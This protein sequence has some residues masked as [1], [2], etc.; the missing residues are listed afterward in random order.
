MRYAALDFEILDTWRTS[1][2][3]VGCVIFEDGRMVDSFYSLVRPPSKIENWHCVQAH[4]LTYADVKNAPSFPDVWEK[5]DAMIGDS[6]IVAHNAPFERSCINTCS[7]MFGTKNGYTYI[8]TLKM[9]RKLLTESKNHRLDTAC[10]R[11]GVK[12]G[13]HHN[14]LDDAKACGEL[15]WKLK[16]IEDLQKQ[17]NGQRDTCG[18]SSGERI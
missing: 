6:P 5:I 14:A 13:V 17:K 3:S 18:N 4:G 12:I 2:C 10:S 8:D 1:V 11:V 16:T 15:F 9:S 7:E